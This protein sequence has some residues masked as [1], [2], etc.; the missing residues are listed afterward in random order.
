[1]MTMTLLAAAVLAGWLLQLWS[2]AVRAGHLVV[3]PLRGRS[4]V[5]LGRQA[6]GRYEMLPAWR[7]PASLAR[8]EALRTAARFRALT[9][10]PL[11]GHRTVA[12]G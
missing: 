6:H 11:R 10:R 3:V 1:M 9:A 8:W 4:P 12:A 2:D 5:F 7:L